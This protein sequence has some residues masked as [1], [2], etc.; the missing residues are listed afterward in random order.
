MNEKIIEGE[1]QGFCTE[2]FREIYVHTPLR[3]V[4]L[5]FTSPYFF[6][7]SVQLPK[8]RVCNF[9]RIE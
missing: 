8:N 4:K 1:M 6:F 2:E 3:E 9:Q 5:N 7:E